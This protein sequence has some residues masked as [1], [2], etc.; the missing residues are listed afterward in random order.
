MA[1]EDLKKF[2]NFYF[3]INLK[4]LSGFMKDIPSRK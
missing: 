4:K 3:I 1:K 2:A